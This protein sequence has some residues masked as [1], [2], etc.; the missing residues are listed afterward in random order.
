MSGS[1]EALLRLSIFVGVFAVL[2]LAE[3]L[4]PRRALAYGRARWFANAGLSALNTGLLR[5]SVLVVPALSVLAAVWVE[6]KGW[7]LLPAAGVTGM[8]A[9]VLG[10]V[11]L[12]LVIYGQHVAF[13]HVPALWRLHRVHHADP[14][15]D[16]STAIRFH[17]IEIVLSQALKI[18]AVLAIGVPATSVLVFEIVLNATSMFSHANVRLP[19]TADALLRLVFVTPD[20]HRVHHSTVMA[21]TNSNFGFNL[22]LWDRLFGTYLARPQGEQTTMP[23]GLESYR[24]S[25]ATRFLWLL[26][27]PF[28]RGPMA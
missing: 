8:A 13:H 5:L 2:A 11:L 23:I 19:R 18:A 4:W 1:E 14:D 12:D 24:G 22:S 16:V 3:W 6:G 9:A 15:F 26:R 17:P 20:M 21:E 25:E 27:F 7:G 28:V 10:F